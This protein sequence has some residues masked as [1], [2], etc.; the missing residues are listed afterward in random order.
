MPHD[1][2][3]AHK[4]NDKAVFAAYADLG[5]YPNMSDEEIA[6]KLLCESVRLAK[7]KDRKKKIVRSKK[8]TQKP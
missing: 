1:L 2:M 4:E 8:N 7:I 6:M 3:E 5:V